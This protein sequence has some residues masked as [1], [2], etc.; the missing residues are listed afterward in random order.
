MPSLILRTAPQAE[1]A[2]ANGLNSL[3]RTAGSSLASALGGTVLTS[4]TVVLAGL[5]YPS[6]AAYRLLFAIC[7]AAALAGALTALAIPLSPASAG[8]PAESAG[9]A[10]AQA[11][12]GE[13]SSG[14][15]CHQS[16]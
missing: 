10:D 13:A 8:D 6:L 2:A 9:V 12:H 4:Q 14:A 16:G 5:A 1:L 15:P 3:A 7:A 11:G